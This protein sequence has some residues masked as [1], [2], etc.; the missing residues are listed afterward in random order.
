MKGEL[1]NLKVA[2]RRRKLMIRHTEIGL[3]L[4]CMK[5]R[6]QEKEL[7]RQLTRARSAA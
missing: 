4:L 2:I 5:L 3:K 6:A 1:A 7:A